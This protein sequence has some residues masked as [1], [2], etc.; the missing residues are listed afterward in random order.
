MSISRA[1]APRIA[2]GCVA[3]LIL[4][5]LAACGLQAPD[6]APTAPAVTVPA[7]QAQATLVARALAV[8]RAI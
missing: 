8:C 3:A 1:C 2:V 6:P 5:S 4:L 7:P